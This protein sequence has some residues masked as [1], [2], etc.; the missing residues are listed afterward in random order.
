MHGLHHHVLRVKTILVGFNL[1]VSIPT[2][3]L[4]KFSLFS[5]IRDQDMIRTVDLAYYECGT[6]GTL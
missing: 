2:A 6:S 3:K 4:P 1:A 5:L